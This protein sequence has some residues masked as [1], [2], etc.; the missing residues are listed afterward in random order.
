MDSKNFSIIIQ[1]IIVGKVN[2]NYENQQTR[3]CIDSINK[4]LPNAEIIIS[5]WVGQDTSHLKYDKVVYSKDP[6]AITYNDFELKNTFNNNNR[7]IVTTYEGLKIATRKYAIKLR[8]DIQ[9]ENTNFINFI[10]KFEKRYKYIFFEKRIIVPTFFSRNPEKIPL[11]FHISDL[12]QV[13]LT[14]DL[15]NL[16]DIPQQPEP[17]TTRFLDY[18]KNISNDPYKRNK[19]KMRYAS[20]QYIWSE[21]CKKNNLNLTLKYFCE[22]PLRLIQKSSISIIDN[23]TILTPQ[24]IG[25]KLPQ[26]LIHGEKKLYSFEEWYNLYDKIC[27]K[28]SKIRLIKLIFNSKIVSY[29]YVFRNIIKDIK[30][31]F[32][33]N[34]K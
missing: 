3:Q 12:F 27:V 5:T 23:F 33:S 28:K 8:S 18:S 10:N 22:V 6:G 25:I 30:N 32:V 24:Q 11:L 34:G 13:G 1:G 26:R 14:K 9:F 15:L 21:F 4:H 19:Y 7:Q 17:E 16:W 31:V 20:E 29:N 2:D